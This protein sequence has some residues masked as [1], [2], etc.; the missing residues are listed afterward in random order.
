MRITTTITTKS[1]NGRRG[2]RRRASTADEDCDDDYDEGLQRPMRIT[3]K[4]TTK[5]IN[6]R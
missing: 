6:D 5:I 4:I 1:I 2:L 3:I